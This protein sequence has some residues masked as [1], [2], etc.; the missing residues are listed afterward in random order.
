VSPGYFFLVM[1]AHSR[2][3]ARAWR[4]GERRVAADL[5]RVLDAACPIWPGERKLHVLFKHFSL[6]P[7]GLDLTETKWQTMDWLE[8]FDRSREW[9]ERHANETRQ[10]LP[11]APGRPIDLKTRDIYRRY[12]EWCRK[13]CLN[14]LSGRIPKE[15]LIDIIPLCYPEWSHSPEKQQRAIEEGVRLAIKTARKSLRISLNY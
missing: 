3:P 9:L 14:P 1:A 15:C 12:L 11:K 6:D 10:V 2:P 4:D 7:L 8:W 13:K 5:K